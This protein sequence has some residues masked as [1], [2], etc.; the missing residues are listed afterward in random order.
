VKSVTRTNALAYFGFMSVTNKKCFK[1]L[2][3]DSL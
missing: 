2:L 1:R 3:P